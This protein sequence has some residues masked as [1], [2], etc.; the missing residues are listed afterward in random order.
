M[1]TPARTIA[2]D[3]SRKTGKRRYAPEPTTEGE[4]M[5][6]TEP[7]EPGTP[8]EPTPEEP[9]PDEPKPEGEETS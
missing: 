3:K 9:K 4:T 7:T 6:E 8:T 2:S 5:F 1:G